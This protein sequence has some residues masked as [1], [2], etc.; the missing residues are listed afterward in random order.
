MQKHHKVCVGLVS[1]AVCLIDQNKAL[2]KW[3]QLKKKKKKRTCGSLHLSV[4]GSW[5]MAPQK[6]MG[7][8]IADASFITAISTWL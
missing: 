3:K 8:K 6:E 2:L 4:K 1:T 5:G 7:L